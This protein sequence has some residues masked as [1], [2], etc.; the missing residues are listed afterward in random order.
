V[1]GCAARETDMLT[2]CSRQA[3]KKKTHIMASMLSTA[4]IDVK[5]QEDPAVILV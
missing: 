3:S 5:K 2:I 1:L 4:N